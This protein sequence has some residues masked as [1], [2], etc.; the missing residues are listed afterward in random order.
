ML[1]PFLTMPTQ[2]LF[3]TFLYWHAKSQA[4]SSL[5]S[6]Y[7][8]WLENPVIWLTRSILANI[9]GYWLSLIWDL[10]RYIVTKVTKFQYR[11][12]WEVW[13]N[14]SINSKNPIF[15]PFW[16]DSFGGIF[17]K[18]YLLLQNATVLLKNATIITKCS[19]YYKL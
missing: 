9:S 14:F 18:N 2:K 6:K 17:L 4:I 12:Y 16:G 15:S 7:M 8:V 5:C 3:K 13:L 11:P 19:I 1:H 10:C